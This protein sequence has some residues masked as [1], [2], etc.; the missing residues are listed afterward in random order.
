MREP[1]KRGTRLTVCPVSNEVYLQA[2]AEGI[3]EQL[4]DCGVQIINPGCGSCRTQSIGVVG[5]G[6]AM[7]STGCYNFSGCAGTEDSKVYLAS[8]RSVALA[9]VGGCIGQAH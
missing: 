5:D 8:T 3:I 7:I 4:I 2:V 1:Y 9:S 6:E